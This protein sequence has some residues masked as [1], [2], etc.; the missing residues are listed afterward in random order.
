MKVSGGER[1]FLSPGEHFNSAGFQVLKS[2]CGV[3]LCLY[4]RCVQV[5]SAQ[6]LHQH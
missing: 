2:V 6:L 4:P 3:S 5:A 1:P